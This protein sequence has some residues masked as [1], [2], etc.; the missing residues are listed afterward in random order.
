MTRASPQW[1]W[2]RLLVI[3]Q[4]VVVHVNE[5]TRRPDL[6]EPGRA[7]AEGHDSSWR[8][9]AGHNPSHGGGE[10]DG[11]TDS[12]G[13]RGRCNGRGCASRES[14]QSLADADPWRGN[15]QGIV[16]FP[17]S[18]TTNTLSNGGPSAGLPKLR[19]LRLA[20]LR[21]R[22]RRTSPRPT[23]EIGDRADPGGCRRGG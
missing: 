1:G 12:R 10:G 2:G 9:A 19:T 18:V 20:Y 3:V 17:P 23:P 6:A 13:G 7:V 16:A 21:S 14:L 11:V 8:A 4:V 22:R 5:E 15:R